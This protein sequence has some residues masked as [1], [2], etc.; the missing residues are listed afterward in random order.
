LTENDHCPMCWKPLDQDEWKAG[1]PPRYHPPG[2]PSCPPDDFALFCQFDRP[3]DL[4]KMVRHFG[5]YWNIPAATWQQYDDAYRAWQYR[6]TDRLIR[7]A[8]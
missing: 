7:G 5:G 3:P 4:Q 1:D 8:K 2:A 6:R